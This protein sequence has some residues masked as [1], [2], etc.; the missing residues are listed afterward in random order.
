MFWKMVEIWKMKFSTGSANNGKTGTR[1]PG[2]GYPQYYSGEMGWRQVE[3]DFSSFFAIF[4]DFS[5]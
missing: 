2:F 4:D 5:K 1:K 3:H